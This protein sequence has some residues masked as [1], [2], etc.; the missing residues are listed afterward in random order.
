MF[1]D[2]IV[3]NQYLTSYNTILAYRIKILLFETVSHTNARAHTRISGVS[4]CIFIVLPCSWHENLNKKDGNTFICTVLPR[5]PFYPGETLFSLNIYIYI[6][7]YTHT[8]RI[9]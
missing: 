7:K 4:F 8:V 9:R 6:Y 3:Q 5:S 1:I 2:H